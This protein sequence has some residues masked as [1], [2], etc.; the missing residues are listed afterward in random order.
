MSRSYPSH[1]SRKGKSAVMLS[2]IKCKGELSPRSCGVYFL[3]II[4][5]MNWS[6]YVNFTLF[7]YSPCFSS[8]NLYYKDILRIKHL[9][10]SGT[11]YVRFVKFLKSLM[12]FVYQVHATELD[13]RTVKP[14]APSTL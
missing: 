12:K 11:F 4:V 5:K 8:S 10:H 14:S 1:V 2:L 7:L 3:W 13:I 9:L 6:D